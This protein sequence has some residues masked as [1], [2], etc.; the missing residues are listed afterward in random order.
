MP[1]PYA[2]L[3]LAL[4]SRGAP[5][6]SVAEAL[7]HAR[8]HLSYPEYEAARELFDPLDLAVMNGDFAS[9][10]ASFPQLD[11]YAAKQTTSARVEEVL[12]LESIASIEVGDDARAVALADAL[13]KRLPALMKETPTEGRNTVL[14]LRRR[15]GRIADADFRADRDAWA[16]DAMTMWPPR[17]ANNAWFYFYAEPASSALDAREALDALSRFSPLPPYDGLVHH[18]RWMGHVLL[19]AGRI[20]EAIPH[21]RRAISACWLDD[22]DYVISHQAAAQLLGEALEAKGDKDGACAAYAE[23]LTHWGNAKP[24]SVTADK[25]RGRSKALGC[26]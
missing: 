14:R 22:P 20:D 9:V 21:L 11:A 2:W 4:F 26:R 1:D 15:A 18:E 5:T 3:A 7:R 6:E 24:R 16:K 13:M 23:V 17:L 25:A 12:A 8:E 19:L 10:L